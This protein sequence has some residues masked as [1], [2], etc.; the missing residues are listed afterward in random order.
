MSVDATAIDI[1]RAKAHRAKVARARSSGVIK[2]TV[3]VGD[4]FRHRN[5]KHKLVKVIEIRGLMAKVQDLRTGKVTDVQL[6]SKVPGSGVEIA[7]YAKVEQPS[8]P[9]AVEPEEA[10][11][12]AP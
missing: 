11:D 9:A 5:T 1:E 6:I 4:T 8:E 12:A 7:N 10:P 2:K 3:A